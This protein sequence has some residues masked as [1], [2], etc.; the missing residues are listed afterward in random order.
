MKNVEKLWFKNSVKPCTID[1]DVSCSCG[2]KSEAGR[3]AMGNVGHFVYYWRL[4][5]ESKRP[6]GVFAHVRADEESGMKNRSQG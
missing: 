5:A 4:V 2:L 1:V 3:R 6:I